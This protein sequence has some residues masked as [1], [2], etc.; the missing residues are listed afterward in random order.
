[1]PTRSSRLV[2][3]IATLLALT[4]LAGGAQFAM[5][6]PTLTL[7]EVNSTTL[8]WSWDDGS[9]SGDLISGGTGDSWSGAISGPSI[10]TLVGL[11]G[12][13]QEPGS[14]TLFNN[15]TV[16]HQNI[17]TWNVAALSD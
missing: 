9:G 5:A 11:S 13:W 15:V 7:I 16:I 4:I 1:M 3:S 6:I 14:T 2:R 12:S 17:T 8:H 10:A